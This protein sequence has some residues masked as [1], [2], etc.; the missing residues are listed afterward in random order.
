MDRAA[1]AKRFEGLVRELGEGYALLRTLLLTLPIPM[2]L[3][4]RQAGAPVEAIRAL[5]RA[6]ELMEHERVSKTLRHHLRSM[7]TDWLTAYE[8]AVT[9]QEMGPAPWRIRGI[10]AALARFRASA[11]YAATHLK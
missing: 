6:W 8:L 7:I 5:S 1:A 10:E 3:I 2:R 11:E 9:A 4:E